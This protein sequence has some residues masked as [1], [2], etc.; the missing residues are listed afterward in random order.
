MLTVEI[1]KTKIV[2]ITEDTANKRYLLQKNQQI[3]FHPVLL[4]IISGDVNKKNSYT[5]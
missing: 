5:S 2:Q 1:K 4:F 3:S